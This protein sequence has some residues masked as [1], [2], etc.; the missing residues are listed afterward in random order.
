MPVELSQETRALVEG[1]G[2]R[3]EKRRVMKYPGVFRKLCKRVIEDDPILHNLDLRGFQLGEDGGYD[4]AEALRGNRN[5]QEINLWVNHIGDGGAVAIADV[6]QR[7]GTI[8]SL[9]MFN[10]DIG[11]TGAAAFADVLARNK[12]L[13]SLGFNTNQI[14]CAGAIALAQALGRNATLRR[15]DLSGNQ[16]GDD[17]CKA[18][19]EALQ[20]NTFLT[21]L[22]LTNNNNVDPSWVEQVTSLLER[23]QTSAHNA[24]LAEMEAKRQEDHS[25]PIHSLTQGQDL[26]T[27]AG[28]AHSDLAFMHTEV[29]LDLVDGTESRVDKSPAHAHVRQAVESDTTVCDVNQGVL[30]KAASPVRQIHG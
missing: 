16:I 18:L 28:C 21:E 4:L 13:T 26:S 22:L 6:M 3:Y 17:G 12:S 30:Y 29:M 7:N 15:L 9:D 11:D 23:N 2:P 20:N 19:C 24:Q 8:T 1:R 25:Y 10:N 14:G 27:I 5:L